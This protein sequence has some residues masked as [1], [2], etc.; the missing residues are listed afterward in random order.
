MAALYDFVRDQI[1]QTR[2]LE[3]KEYRLSEERHFVRRNA[4]EAIARLFRNLPKGLFQFSAD[5][6]GHPETTYL[7]IDLDG[8]QGHISNHQQITLTRI[9]FVERDGERFAID[10]DRG[11]ELGLVN[12]W[13]FRDTWSGHP[14]W[15]RYQSHPDYRRV[16]LDHKLHGHTNRSDVLLV[17][18]GPLL[19][20]G[21]IAAMA[22]FAASVIAG[23]Q[24]ETAPLNAMDRQQ[25]KNRAEGENIQARVENAVS[26]YAGLDALLTAH[27]DLA[28]EIAAMDW[29]Y[30]YA[31]RPAK[32]GYER[33]AR[34][35]AGL[36]TLSL[37]DATALF[38]AK[39]R[40]YWT[41]LL[42]YLQGI[43]R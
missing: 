13:S 15:M 10:L 3:T 17:L 35:R 39:N 23:G 11:T 27:E 5:A 41:K 2:A 7:R 34:I 6:L 12:E 43:R 24:A 20:H 31:D 21:A 37:E 32:S 16:W 40:I 28:R 33:E 9:G 1:T 4:V 18:T 8:P 14:E 22:K 42:T 36:K 30:D 38:L 25:A 29:T 26:R 19:A